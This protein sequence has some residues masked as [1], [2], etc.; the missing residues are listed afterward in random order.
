MPAKQISIPLLFGL[1]AAICSILFVLGT[2]LGGPDVFI[3]PV[4]YLSVP[5][6]VIIAAVAA[7]IAKRANAGILVFRSA[8]R[9]SYGV[10]VLGIVAQNLFNWLLLN[11]IDPHF[12]QRLVPVLLTKA[13]KSY[14]QYGATDDQLRAALDDI[15]TN[16]QFSLGRVITGTGFQLVLCFLIA[17]LIAVTV[18]SKQGLTPKPG[19]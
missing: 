4:S 12:Y 17:L 5:M 19:Q 8:L 11:V 15:R 13:E 7:A 16:N 14:R 2:W 1:I 3:G 10:L 18:K 9:I 6:I